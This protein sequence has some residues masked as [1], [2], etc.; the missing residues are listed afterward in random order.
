MPIR[1]GQQHLQ[2]RQVN[3]ERSVEQDEEQRQDERND[4]PDDENNERLEQELFFIKEQE[5]NNE[6][7]VP[8]QAQP[9]DSYDFSEELEHRAKFVVIR[10]YTVSTREG[11]RYYLRLLLHYVRRA[12][13]YKH[14]RTV[15]GEECLSFRGSCQ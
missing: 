14:M 5:H 4:H 12:T 6:N 7:P 10:I 11:G 3:E 15:D 1:T 9:P 2:E 8:A 13:S